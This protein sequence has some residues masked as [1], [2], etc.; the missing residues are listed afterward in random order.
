MST[1]IEIFEIFDQS[2]DFQNFDHQHRD[3]SKISTKVEI[4]ANFHQN[5]NFRKFLPK[6]RFFVLNFGQNRHFSKISRF[7]KD[8]DQNQDFRKFRPKSKIF[9]HISVQI[10][11]YKNFHRNCD[12]SQISTKI[13][14]SQTFRP[15]SRFC[16]NFDQNQDF[17]NNFH[18]NR[19]FWKF[20]PKSRF[21][22]ISAK[23]KIFRKYRYF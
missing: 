3:Y 19:D 13:A 2:R 7:L 12:F 18:R 11:I 23:I 16:G 5:R 20:P 8:F 9:L 21:L 6:S 4:Y 10:K 15:I 22:K 1:K 17:F 14:I